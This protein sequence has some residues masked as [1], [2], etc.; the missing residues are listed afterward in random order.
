ME[1]QPQNP[2]F[3]NNPKIFHPYSMNTKSGSSMIWDHTVCNNDIGYQIKS[4]DEK[5]DNICLDWL[6]KG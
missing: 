5:A 2:E 4:A 1:S 3:S 6:H